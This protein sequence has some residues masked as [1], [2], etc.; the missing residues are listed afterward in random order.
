MGSNIYAPNQGTKVVKLFING[1]GWLDP[2]TFKIQFDVRN[3]ETQPLRTISGPW[4]FF[5]RTRV[6]CQGQLIEDIDHYNLCHQMFDVLQSKH[7]REN[8]DVESFGVRYDSAYSKDLIE[9]GRT[10]I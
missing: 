9:K 2:S 8:Q 3:L 10:L 5:R 4:S 7:V 1:D 6:L